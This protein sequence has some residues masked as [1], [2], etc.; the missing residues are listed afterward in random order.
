VTNLF[1]FDDSK[2]SGYLDASATFDLGSGWSVVPH[3]GHQKVKNLSAASYTDYS[4][5]LGKDFGGGFS[6]SAAVVGTDAEKTVYFTPAGKFTGK[7]GLVVGAKYT[8]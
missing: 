6:A 8:F 5:T 1:G 4:V 2:N 3:V 7:T